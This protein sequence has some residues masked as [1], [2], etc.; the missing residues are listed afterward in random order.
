MEEV[1]GTL[2]PANLTELEQRLKE[3]PRTEYAVVLNQVILGQIKSSSAWIVPED[4]PT[5]SGDLFT[6]LSFVGIANLNRV[7]SMSKYTAWAQTDERFRLTIV[8]FVV[9]TDPGAHRRQGT[10]D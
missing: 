9:V 6:S 4:G 7:E 2:I 1:D 5:G 3:E 8:R 10:R